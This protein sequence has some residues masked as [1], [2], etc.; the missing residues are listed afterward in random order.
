M[1]W[2]RDCVMHS[3]QH[4]IGTYRTCV[5]SLRKDTK[6]G[7]CQCVCARALS[8]TLS[9]ARALPLPLPLPLP[10][11]SLSSAY[12]RN[13][14]Y[15]LL[16]AKPD[17]KDGVIFKHYVKWKRQTVWRVEIIR[18]FNTVRIW[19]RR[20]RNCAQLSACTETVKRQRVH[21][22]GR[23]IGQGI[24]QGRTINVLDPPS[25]PLPP[26]RSHWKEYCITSVH[27]Y[28]SMTSGHCKNSPSKS[29]AVEL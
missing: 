4:T 29:T 11:S 27:P 28:Q 22:L 12:Q 15:L 17:G 18:A 23:H 2:N 6:R 19:L 3:C 20:H 7:T 25:P 14:I 21:W 26:S 9:L 5:Q 16:I 1:A 10:L 8:L 24:G 13:C